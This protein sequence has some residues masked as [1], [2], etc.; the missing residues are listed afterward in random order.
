MYLLDKLGKPLG[1]TKSF[2]YKHTFCLN[3]VKCRFC[4]LCGH[5]EI[6]YDDIA[7]ISVVPFK[8]AMGQFYNGINDQ[9]QHVAELSQKIFLYRKHDYTVQKNIF[10]RKAG[11]TG[12]ELNTGSQPKKYTR[13]C[14]KVKTYSIAGSF[15]KVSNVVNFFVVLD[16]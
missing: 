1:G 6:T 10:S 15:L 3:S 5:S 14:V 9:I 13:Y 16:F 11:R 8:F 4:P 2:I 7:H 12:C